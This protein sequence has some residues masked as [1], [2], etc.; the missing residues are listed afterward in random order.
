MDRVQSLIEKLYRRKPEQ[1]PFIPAIKLWL[2]YCGWS[3][4]LIVST[5]FL[6]GFNITP[7]EIVVVLALAWAVGLVLIVGTIWMIGSVVGCLG[8]E[9]SKG[10][11]MLLALL[12][13]LLFAVTGIVANQLNPQNALP[14]PYLIFVGVGL[15]ILQFLFALYAGNGLLAIERNSN[16]ERHQESYEHEAQANES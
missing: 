2:G 8:F 7:R 16:E 12:T 15:P 11:A 9:K 1:S 10:K 5:N 13:G 4:L 3:T 6:V 14:I